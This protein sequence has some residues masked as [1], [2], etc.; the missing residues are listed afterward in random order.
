MTGSLRVNKAMKFFLVSSV[1]QNLINRVIVWKIS[2]SLPTNPAKIFFFFLLN[3][4]IAVIYLMN[5]CKVLSSFS[6]RADTHWAVSRFQSILCKPK[7]WLCGGN[8]S[9]AAGS[10]ILWAAYGTSHLNQLSSPLS[11][12]VWIS[13]SGLGHTHLPKPV[14][15]L[16][17][18]SW[19]GTASEVVSV[20][21]FSFFPVIL[22]SSPSPTAIQQAGNLRGLI[23]LSSQRLFVQN[24]NTMRHFRTENKI[25]CESGQINSN[26]AFFS[27]LFKKE[28]NKCK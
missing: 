16:L 2:E 21:I 17:T 18:S 1:M 4:A 20:C 5:P 14:E 9:R 28:N 6:L 26:C 19:T 15:L 27:L 3:C 8:P 22:K 13:A 25:R 12:S 7:R 24:I 11:C 10:E 23:V